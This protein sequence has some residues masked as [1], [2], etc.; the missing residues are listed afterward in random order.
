MERDMRRKDKQ[1]PDK[2][3][4]DDVLTRG[5][6]L[7]LGLATPDGSPYVLPIGYAYEDGVIL[8]HG[9]SKGLKNDLIAANPRVSFN[10]TLDAELM[11]DENG[12]EFSFKYRSVTG[13]GDASEIT[14]IDLKN[15]ALASLMGHYGGPH[16]D[17]TPE[18]GRA[19]WVAKIVIRQVTGKCSGYPKP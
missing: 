18:R 1:V 13:F 8:L 4:I 10:V 14:D 7:F 15:A 9:A 16:T 6:Y 2:G 12:S 17:I 19:V 11:R 3:W 5:E